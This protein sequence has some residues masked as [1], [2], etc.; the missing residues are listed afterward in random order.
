MIHPVRLYQSVYRIITAFTIFVILTGCAGGRD[1]TRPDPGSLQLGKTT[2]EEVIQKYGD[3]LRPTTK[4]IDGETVNEISYSYAY[5]VPYTTTVRSRSSSFSF[6][7]GALIGYRYT[8]SFPE[9][10][11]KF[12]DG[13]VSAITRGV[14][15]KQQVID[16]L[17]VPAG[18]SQYPLIKEKNTLGLV[19][20]AYETWRIPFTPTLRYITKTLIVTCG[21]DDIVISTELSSSESK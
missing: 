8:S 11:A 20:T 17:G 21:P 12:D 4:I 7:K 6:W 14:T 3:P 1:F 18:Y 2:Y 16:L 15:K 13:K 5:A 10:N 19:Y 9:D